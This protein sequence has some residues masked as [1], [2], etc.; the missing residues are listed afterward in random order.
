MTPSTQRQSA[1]RFGRACLALCVI[2]S[3]GLSG[4]ASA[5]STALVHPVPSPASVEAGQTVAV[6]V[7]ID[8]VQNLY[9]FDI[10]LGFDPS[11][12][13]VVDEDAG[14]EGVQIRPGDLLKSDFVVRNLADNAAGTVWYALTQLNPSEEVSG[15]GVAFTV[16]F[17]GKL[18]GASSPL[19][20]VYQKLATRSGDQIPASTANGEIRVVQAG[21]PP[22]PTL[23]PPTEVVPTQA[24][25][26][27]EPTEP[28][29]T[30]APSA[31]P[32]ATPLPQETAV[33]P[34]V[35]PTLTT[36]PALAT[37]TSVPTVRPTVV[38]PTSAPATTVPTTIPP[39]AQAPLPTA[40]QVRATLTTKPA[41]TATPVA[42]SSTGASLGWIFYAALFSV[43]FAAAILFLRGR[44]RRRS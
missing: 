42:P 41:P 14:A 9:G 18:A 6:Q 30:V 11:T 31:E 13:E 20:V 7:R 8:D 4:R 29:P 36:A 24:P 19:T 44:A 21:A 17:R 28:L 3:L 25:P 10:R 34:T 1:S 23:P 38:A 2:C 16:T 37:A 43:A 5:Q 32:S 22:T 35:A 12:V 26:T 27:L 33:P 39:T 40:T 15:S